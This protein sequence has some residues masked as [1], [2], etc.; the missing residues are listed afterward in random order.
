MNIVKKFLFFFAFLTTTAFARFPEKDINIYVPFAAG[1]AAETLVRHVAK[2]MEDI[3]GQNVNIYANDKNIKPTDAVRNATSL[4]ADGY[5]LVVGN[6]GTHGSAHALEGISLRYDPMVDF[7]AVAML[8]QTPLY[9]VSR[10]D[11]KVKNFAELV[12]LMRSKKQA[13]TMG[14][15]GKG[16]TAYL[17]ALYF[18]SLTKVQPTMIPYSG[19]VPALQDMSKGYLDVMLDQ[20]TSALPFIQARAVR[21]LAYADGVRDK[22]QVEPNPITPNVRTFTEM[23]L[24]EFDIIGWN[25]LF[26]PRGTP[27]DIILTLNDAVRQALKD[28]YVKVNMLYKNTNIYPDQKNRPALLDLFVKQEVERWRELISIA[29][30]AQEGMKR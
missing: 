1:G 25:M 22:S 2:K 29:E 16:S 12:L 21:P 5:H 6:L 17:A 3:L 19:S 13:I 7:R 8:G 26:A 23:G 10:Y 9:L 15:S 24:P 18:N 4:P 27:K 14:Y 11:L 30:S 20:S 28:N